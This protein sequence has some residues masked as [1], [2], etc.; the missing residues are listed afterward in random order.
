MPS[1]RAVRFGAS[2]RLA[3]ASIAAV[4]GVALSG[5]AQAADRVISPGTKVFDCSSAKPG[6]TITIPSGNRD[7]LIIRYCTGAASNPI[8]IRNDPN[9]NGPAVIRRASGASDGFIFSCY[10]CVGVE[11]DGSYKWRGAPGGKTYG[12]KVTLTGGGSPSAF[13]RIGGLSRQ[14]TVR[15]MEIDGAWPKVSNNGSGLR[16]NDDEIKRSKY[17]NLWR[18]GI[19]IEDNYIH[20]VALE[21][22]YVGPNYKVGGLP[23]RNVEIRYNR[24]EDTGFEA[25]NTKSMW[26][27]DN[28]IHHNEVRRAGKNAART[29]DKAQYTGIKNNAGTVKIYNNWIETTGMHGIQAWTQDGPKTS[30]NRG[31]FEVRIWNNVII[32]AGALWKPHMLK[33]AGI[34]VGAEA[35]TEEPIP[36]IYNNTIVN[37]RQSAINLGRNVKAGYIR[38][39]IAAG[40]NGNPV[41][42]APGSMSLTNNRIG[43]VAQMLF[44]DASR[45]DFRLTLNSPA[46][47]Q[48]SSGFPQTDFDDASR[49]KGN[50]PD[51]GAFEAN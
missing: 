3:I 18:E 10:D 26:Q 7:P 2:Y 6:D 21:G 5:A 49:P 9:G 39:N 48:G 13:V 41:I 32:D 27:G 11:I 36:Y 47:N 8:V 33:S 28:S 16:F 38:D 25:I 23:L 12:I 45:M 50:G 51:L 35:G 29:K 14:V 46:R 15:N 17:P 44:E 40:T 4:V 1:V 31:P 34:S 30:E 19:L 42:S 43:T 24:V 22:M 20:D 37:S